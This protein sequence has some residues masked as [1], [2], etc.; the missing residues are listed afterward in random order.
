MRT[1]GVA[2]TLVPESDHMLSRRR[3][4]TLLGGSALV[5]LGACEGPAPAP[6]SIAS[7]S[8][9]QSLHYISLEDVARRIAAREI[10]PLE[11]TR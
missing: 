7:D 3:V 4:L 10:S 1:R 6:R 5:P 8:A 2:V 11:L 9:G